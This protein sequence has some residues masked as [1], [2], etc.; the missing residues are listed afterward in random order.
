MEQW[1]NGDDFDHLHGTAP[2]ARRKIVSPSTL[3]S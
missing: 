1:R 3:F 2:G